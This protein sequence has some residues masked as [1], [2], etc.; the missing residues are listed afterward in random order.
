M[1]LRPEVLLHPNIPKTLHGIAPR[2]ILGDA[3]WNVERQKAYE[4]TNYHCL[5]CGVH[6]L[7]AK[8]HQWLEA[9]E[10]Y[11]YNYPKGRLIF[12]EIVPLCHACHNS[13]HTGRMRILVKKGEMTDIKEQEILDH[14]Y[15][16]L[17]INKLKEPKPPESCA[18]WL[19]W[20]MVVFG[21]EY[22]PSTQNF[23]EWKSG[24]WRL[25]KP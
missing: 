4:S 25:W 20:R 19:D 15:N 24:K 8:Y 12:K 21:K 2:K 5:A 11:E 23:Q 18:D 16:I 1:I 3:W 22:G 10:I 6:K 17:K 13:I 9:H 14:K 7:K